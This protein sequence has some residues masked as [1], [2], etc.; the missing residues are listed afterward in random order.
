MKPESYDFGK[1]FGL[2]RRISIK[3]SLKILKMQYNQNSQ[4]KDKEEE[5]SPNKK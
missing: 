2:R 4:I 1:N 3:I 5:V